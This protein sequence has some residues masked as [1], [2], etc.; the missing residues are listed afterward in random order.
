VLTRKERP[1]LQIES[2]FGASERPIAPATLDSIARRREMNPRLRT[3]ASLIRSFYLMI[4]IEPLAAQ[5]NP[6]TSS[7]RS[8]PPPAGLRIE[9]ADISA[10]I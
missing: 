8:Y 6:T 7:V 10:T 1:S 9:I 4:S 2:C 5:L 3:R